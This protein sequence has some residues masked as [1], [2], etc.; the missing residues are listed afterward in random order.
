MKVDW[1]QRMKQ[2]VHKFLLWSQI[3]KS[4]WE[5]EKMKDARN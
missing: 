3:V 5:A 2:S 1:N 4:D